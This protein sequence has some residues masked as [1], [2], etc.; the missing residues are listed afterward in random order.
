MY[1]AIKI[2]VDNQTISQ[3][4]INGLEDLQKIVEGRIEVVPFEEPLGNGDVCYGNEEGLFCFGDQ[5]KG[6]FHIQGAYQ[7]TK[8]NGV[9]VGSTEEGESVEPKIT[10]EEVKSITEFKDLILV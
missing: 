8:G 1:K 9:I 2:D 10:V 6:W 7:P 5:P 3:V 4:E